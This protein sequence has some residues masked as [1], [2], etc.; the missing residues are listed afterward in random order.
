LIIYLLPLDMVSELFLVL[1][2]PDMKTY[3]SH[4][5]NPPSSGLYQ[6]KPCALGIPMGVLVY[7]KYIS[8]ERAIISTC[9]G[10]P[11]SAASGWVQR[12]H[13]ARDETYNTI[14]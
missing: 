14:C 9:C 4:T 12:D 6:L 7:H 10:W 5:E 8:T 3:F 1:H 13:P 2:V 11:F